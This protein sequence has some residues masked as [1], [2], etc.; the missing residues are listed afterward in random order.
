VQRCTEVSRSVRD[1]PESGNRCDDAAS[2]VMRVL[3][4]D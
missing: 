2:A 1:L 4:R 3:D